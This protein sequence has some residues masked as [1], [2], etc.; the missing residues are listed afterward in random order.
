MR[1]LIAVLVLVGLTACGGGGNSA[2][3]AVATPTPPTKAVVNVLIDPNPITAVSSGDPN[4]PWDF[5]VNLQV[6]DS[7]GVP[8]VVTS[9]ETTITS[10]I[11]GGVLVTTQQNPFVGVKI[12]A[13][14]QETRQ[15]HVGAYRMENFTRQGKVTFKM[16]FSDDH[17]NASVF[18][19][20]VNVLNVGEP[21]RF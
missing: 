21:V 11:S 6:S 18:T 1:N 7:G 3:T 9:M 12:P 14:G 15:F 16:N 8:F 20:S 4:F 10:A 5:R 17:G 19:G 13:L 2:P